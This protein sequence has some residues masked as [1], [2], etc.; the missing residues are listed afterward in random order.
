MRNDNNFHFPLEFRFKKLKCYKTKF[1]WEMT[2]IFE[3][4]ILKISC[5]K[6]VI[7][8]MFKNNNRIKFMRKFPKI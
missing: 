3:I 5:N 1:Q 4:F 2:I 8:Q 6:K 7:V